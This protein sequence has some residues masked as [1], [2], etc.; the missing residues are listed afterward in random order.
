MII[1]IKKYNNTSLYA[2]AEEMVEEE[3][4]E[5]DED[6]EDDVEQMW[7]QSGYDGL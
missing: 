7:D 5:V 6:D 2:F 1:F 4:D 3:D